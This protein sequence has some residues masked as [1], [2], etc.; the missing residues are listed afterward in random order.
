MISGYW[1][2]A[3]GVG[4]PIVSPAAGTSDRMA[5]VGVG[6]PGAVLGVEP[7]RPLF[8]GGPDQWLAHP[9]RAEVGSALEHQGDDPAH[10]GGGE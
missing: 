2:A 5:R 4:R 8:A 6:Q 3:A 1:R 9:L 10:L 7:V